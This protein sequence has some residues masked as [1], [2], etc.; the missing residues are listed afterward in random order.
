MTKKRCNKIL[1]ANRGEIARRIARTIKEEKRIAVGLSSIRD[2]TANHLRACDESILVDEPQVAQVFLRPDI[3][4]EAAKEAGANAIHPG[5]GFLSE[6]P[7]LATACHEA[8]LIFIG[9]TPEL[10]ALFGDKAKTKERAK[11]LGIPVVETR[12]VDPS[13]LEEFMRDTKAQKT[14]SYPLLIKA[15]GGGGGRGMRLV[16]SATELETSISSASREAEKFFGDGT[17]LIEPFLREIKHLEVQ[18]ASDAHGNV[19]HLYE[20]ECS[21]Q[22]NY[23]KILE[24]AP[25]QGIS[26]ELRNRLFHDAI[27][28]FQDLNYEGLATV[29]FLVTP[30]EQYYFT[31]VNPR[32]Q[33][34][35]TVTEEIL[36]IDL[37]SLQLHIAEGKSIDSYDIPLRDIRPSGH[38]IQ[39]RINAESSLDFLPQ[40]GTLRECSFPG[41]SHSLLSDATQRGTGRLGAVRLEH[42]VER[43]SVVTADYDSLIAKCIQHAATREEAIARM[44][45]NLQGA[46]IIGVETNIPFLLRVLEE[47]TWRKASYT[48]DITSALRAHTPPLKN[49]VIEHAAAALV[50][51]YRTRQG[52]H[53]IRTSHSESSWDVKDG[54]RHSG[55]PQ[56]AFSVRCK[57][58]DIEVGMLQVGAHEFHLTHEDTV[59]RVTLSSEAQGTQQLIID[60]NNHRMSVVALQHNDHGSEEFWVE[61]PMFSSS[62]EISRPTLRKDT[63][64]VSG[65][66]RTIHSPLPGKVLR[67]LATV[68]QKI[69]AGEPLILLE[70]MKMEHTIS[71]QS[72]GSIERLEVQEGDV[73][74]SGQLLVTVA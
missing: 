52:S 18:I 67:L 6:S 31:E 60:G 65:V 38:A 32:L 8:G 69:E 11:Q 53:P 28:L 7:A 45:Q 66:C 74:S 59:Y 57:G 46:V 72:E 64:G 12:C 49:L 19:I 50:S 34:E 71:S 15:R 13:T 25:S 43:G 40:T 4:I 41:T 2:V 23:Q 58:L 70:S 68:G 56:R 14:L 39:A 37:V 63:D 10:L 3:I 21:A 44:I 24:E 1:I 26:S 5:Y 35:H 29:E 51:L 73:V 30:D 48:T 17:L 47:D 27:L 22:R 55:S 20:R 9:P 61:G 33:V 42:A 36:D 54:F 16:Q 62:V